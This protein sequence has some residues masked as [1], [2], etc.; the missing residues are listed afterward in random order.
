MFQIKEKS[1]LPGFG[2]TMGLTL[3]YLSFMVLIPFSGLL[4]KVGG[5]TWEKYWATMTSN[6]VVASFKLTFGASFLAACINAFFGFIV[7]W[8]LVRYRFPFRRVIDAMVDLPFA[9]PTAVSGIALT[10]LYQ[11]IG[12]MLGYK[13]IFTPLGVL[14]ALTFI[15]L[16]FV[17]RTLQP[18]IED[19]ERELEEVSAS[20]GAS[21][22]QTF[23]RV[24]FPAVRPALITGFAMAFAR[25]LGEYGSV[26]F[27]AG[28]MPGRRIVSL[29][30]VERLNENSTSG[31]LSAVAVAVTMLIASFILLFIINLFQ[32]WMNRRYLVSQ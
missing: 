29:E 32:T 28:S 7:A 25:A 23:W 8:V 22:W 17:V 24:I 12:D 1:V 5:I 9:M 31:D 14:V 16:P 20:L 2:L 18:A 4:L 11:R 3:V 10:A 26:I 6:S 27:I 13:I 30:I 15:G 21:R 19:V